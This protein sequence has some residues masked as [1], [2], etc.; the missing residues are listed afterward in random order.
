V[1]FSPRNVLDSFPESSR[2][3]IKTA[4]TIIE[5]SVRCFAAKELVYLTDDQGVLTFKLTPGIASIQRS[6]QV[7]ARVIG[8]S[9]PH[10]SPFHL[11]LLL[12]DGNLE[13]SHCPVWR[14]LRSRDYKSVLQPSNPHAILNV[15][16]SKISKR[17]VVV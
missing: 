3:C 1:F 15:A 13:A 16:Y 4:F 9:F 11:T 12:Q 10:F 2:L 17:S 7:L 8:E 6:D 14:F 5:I